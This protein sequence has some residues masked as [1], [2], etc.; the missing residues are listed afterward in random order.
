MKAFLTSF[1]LF[2]YFGLTHAGTP[3]ISGV[4]KGNHQFV[5]YALQGSN[6]NHMGHGSPT[7]QVGQLA[8]E[9]AWDWK[10]DMRTGGMTNIDTDNDGNMETLAYDGLLII[11]YNANTAGSDGGD[12]WRSGDGTN[13]TIPPDSTDGSYGDIVGKWVSMG[14]GFVLRYHNAD[15][16][17]ADHSG[18]V[19][20]IPIVDNGDGTYTG[21]ID[22]EIYNYIQPG[23]ERGWIQTTW[24]VTDDGSGNL[25]MTTIDSDT[26]GYAGHMNYGM[27]PFPFEPTFDGTAEP[28]NKPIA[29]AGLDQFARTGELVSL[30]GSDSADP[31]ENPLTYSWTLVNTPNGS[32]PSL[33]NENTSMPS[34]VPDVNGEYVIQLIVAIEVNNTT[35]YSEPDFVTINVNNLPPEADAGFGPIQVIIDN[36]VPL[37]GGNSSDPEDDPLSYQWRFTSKPSGSN[38]I[39]SN[40][41]SVNAS[42]V[43]DVIGDYVVELTVDDGTDSDTA[44]L[45]I[46][47][48]PAPGMLTGVY[49]GDFQF[50]GFAHVDFDPNN[51]P[52]EMMNAVKRIGWEWDFDNMEAR[53]RF[54]KEGWFHVFADSRE[55][56]PIENIDS[57]VLGSGDR[58]V[59]AVM[60]TKP[61][62]FTTHGE[63]PLTY[64]GNG[65]YQGLIDIEIFNHIQGY[66][67]GTLKINWQ[68]I[69]DRNNLTII[70]LDGDGNGY[71]GTVMGSATSNPPW[72][73]F[74][75]PFAPTWD[76]TSSLA[77]VDSND[78]GLMDE[79]ALKLRLDPYLL[80]NDGDGIND[81]IEM[82]DDINNLL[83]FDEDGVPDVFEPGNS[84]KNASR[85]SGFRFEGN[86]SNL[87]TIILALDMSVSG[88]K[89]VHQSGS[90]E[91]FS[92]TVPPGIKFAFNDSNGSS[93][94]L[95]PMF[96]FITTVSNSQQVT[97]RMQ[98]YSPLS[99]VSSSSKSI[100]AS[101]T[102][103]ERAKLPEKLLVYQV[104]TS[105]E[106]NNVQYT[107]ENYILV[108]EKYWKRVDDYTVDI[109]LKDGGSLDSDGTENGIVNAKFVLAQN[110]RGNFDVSG[111]NGGA[112]HPSMLILLLGLL[113]AK[114]LSNHSIQRLQGI[115][116]LSVSHLSVVILMLVALSF[117]ALPS[118]VKAQDTEQTQGT[119]PESIPSITVKTEKGEVERTK[120]ELELE[121]VPGGTNMI[122]LDKKEGSQATLYDVLEF[123]PGVIM[124]KFF[125]GNDQPR[126]NIRGSGIQDNP[127]SRG[128]QLLY[129]GLPINQADGSFI[130]G[131]VD[132][133]QASLVSVYRGANG[134]QYGA[135]TLGGAINFIQRN[136]T[137]SDAIIRLEGGSYNTYN[138]HASFGSQ[139]G[140]WDYYVTGGSEQSDGYRNHNYGERKNLM[141]NVGYQSGDIENRTY[142][143]Y[144]SNF[145]E[146]PFL[147]PKGRAVKDPESVMGDFNDPI[148]R[149]INVYELDPFRD[150]QQYRLANKTTILT[151][152]AEQTIGFYGE[153]VEDYKKNPANHIITD[154]K[155]IGTEYSYKLFV[156]RGIELLPDNYHFTLSANYSDMP[157]EF[158]ANSATGEKHYMF[159]DLG[160]KASNIALGLQAINSLTSSLQTV[161][162]V[163]W[164]TNDRNI[165][166]Q[167][168]PGLLDSDFS[169]QSINP[170][171]G[172]IYHFNDN[173][174]YYTNFS[175]SS[176]A[177][178]FWQLMMVEGEATGPRALRVNP[179]KIQEAE[180]FEIGTAGKLNQINWQF[181]Y[182]YSWIKNELISEI[183]DNFAIKGRTVNYS[184]DTHHQGVE[185]AINSVLFDDMLLSADRL[186]AKVTYNLADY[187]FDGGRY[188]GNDIAGIP[189]HLWQAELKYELGN[190]FVIAPN[191]KWQPVKAYADH[192]NTSVQDPYTLWGLKLFY[193]HKQLHAYVKLDNLTDQ[194]YQASYIIHGSLADYSSDVV[195]S[196]VPGS[197][198]NVSTGVVIKF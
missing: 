137:N 79:Y 82:G 167:Q 52:T 39:I 24:E 99:S 139:Q 70:T 71:P 121:E 154:A 67:R 151:N 84:A 60:L 119:S 51:P 194:V 124:H 127:L 83:D 90:G 102:Q 160:L 128:V 96:S 107:G 131:L 78:D 140:N 183:Q 180:T 184:D 98:F 94:K 46:T 92:Q 108:S 122:E 192:V 132:P 88:E 95:V 178:T 49:K 156:D 1:L 20:G 93:D 182:Y 47:S 18:D 164:V 173:I 146:S 158:Y 16:S 8:D 59:Q 118:L 38:A 31:D 104:D 109:Y 169:Y 61:F 135:S 65:V 34:F 185:L 103:T 85:A 77:S 115:V 53:F 142:L 2:V 193:N 172:L 72:A 181:S 68:M 3:G 69:R 21:W 44:I 14:A 145:F 33:V 97:A 125:G 86:D 75:F 163:Q 133:Q 188:K 168:N 37:D 129:D 15:S 134:M 29:N 136:G 112:M 81:V 197:G 143:N 22:F 138:A 191:V 187:K 148:D 113:L 105:I 159:G 10:W 111:G 189:K 157:R 155:T 57:V 126:L 175:L 63:V 171:V 152:N 41:N 5:G 114:L 162:S 179:L 66:R 74:P 120:I 177:P 165:T 170:K 23:I 100:K 198:F 62:P 54:D 30:D 48:N 196:F 26:N 50:I 110:Y 64:L 27:F 174:R 147:L 117:T 161:A 80:D 56:Q 149:G 153:Q 73:G 35:I 130:I 166:D 45:N 58:L 4:Y 6:H 13:G 89:I 87:N 12:F 9:L 176:E 186:S 116:H 55:A 11:N 40:P 106:G 42:F 19:A 7:G 195:P 190:G 43:A 150:T 28:F 76:G 91:P 36:T 141:M 25:T 123:E 17:L 144:T 32:S 101:G